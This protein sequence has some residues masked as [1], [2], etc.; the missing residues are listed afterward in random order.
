MIQPIQMIPVCSQAQSSPV[1]QESQAG[2]I[3][4]LGVLDRMGLVWA[5][6]FMH[7]IL[8]LLL[9]QVLPKTYH[10]LRLKH[11]LSPNTHSDR[12]YTISVYIFG[13]MEI[14]VPHAESN[15]WERIPSP[16]TL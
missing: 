12:D 9:S 4:R 2:P 6:L 15:N 10:I 5:D 7:I 1:Q 16:L 13:S 14:Y 8:T 11:P 3:H